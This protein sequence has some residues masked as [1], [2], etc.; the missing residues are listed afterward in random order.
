MTD[1]R[2]PPAGTPEPAALGIDLGT[3]LSVVAQVGA[4]GLPAVLPNALGSATTPSVVFFDGTTAAVGQEAVR[5]LATD[6]DDV[7]Q[8]VKRHLGSDWSFGYRGIS[9]RPEH[10]CALILRKLHADAA[11]LAGP[12]TRAAVTVP[13]YFNDPMRAATRRAAELAGLDVTGL[14]SEPTAAA[15]AF[16]HDRRPEGVTGVVVDLGGGTFDVTVMEYEGSSLA[17]RATG[18]DFYLG[19]ANFDMV[20]FDYLAERFRAEHG[21]DLADPDAFSVE[22]CVQVSQDWLHLAAAAK[23]ELTDRDATCVPLAAAGLLLRVPVSRDTFA[24]RSKQLLDEVSEKILQVLAAAGVAAADVG[25]VLAVGGSTRIPAVRERIADIFGSPPDTSVPPDEA[26]ALGAALFA[27]QRQLEGGSLVA[28]DRSAREYL[29][30]LT[31]TDVAAHSVGVPVVGAAGQLMEPMLPRNT[32]LPVEASRTLLTAR[33]G[34]RR[35]VVPVLEGED[36][37]PALCRRIGE[38]VI[39]GL[40]PGRPAH[41]QVLVRMR[42]DSDGIVQVSAAD[43]ET[44]MEASTT[45]VHDNSQPSAAADR[46]VA[47]L[48]VR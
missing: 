10:V 7:V 35:I 28:M 27:A 30:R 32:P 19:G 34:E 22:E 33:P 38:V 41:Q 23:H 43:V 46:A 26:V 21:I 16:G 17:V 4:D 15:L 36:P 39:D 3:T 24:A 2:H 42:L 47:A 20:L 5:A 37:D 8:L 1:G 6:P 12:V 11:R 45:I 9:Y 14:L 13:A 48:T 25:F 29:E 44:G 18:G 31:I 40:P